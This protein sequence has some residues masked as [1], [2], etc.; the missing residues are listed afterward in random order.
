MRR[1]Y[2][3]AHAAETPDL[4]GDLD[5][6]PWNQAEVGRVEWYHPSGSDHTP[7]VHFRILADTGALWVRYVVAD[8]WVR[9][10][11][12]VFQGPVFEDSCCE[13]FLQPEGAGGYFNVE[14]NA[15]GAMMTFYITD[16]AR[17][18]D[19]FAGQ[20]KLGPQ[21]DREIK[22]WTSIAPNADGLIDP[23]IAEPLT[24]ELGI[25]IPFALLERYTR[26]A[27]PADLHEN[28]IPSG[29]IW[30]GNLHKCSENSSH[31]HWGAWSPIGGRLDYHQP[32]MFG[33]FVFL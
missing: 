32:E 17:T 19:G 10:L 28:G 18:A 30:R 4:D 5:R 15:V 12:R 9:C 7:A 13:I 23:E 33:E 24:W 1:R 3:I 14:T 21:A 22:R 16:P 20:T 6:S 31:P 29:T 27:L 25:R 26:P 8:R 11:H 2:E